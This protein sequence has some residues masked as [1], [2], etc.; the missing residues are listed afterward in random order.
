MK[1][2]VIAMCL[3]LVVAGCAGM[4]AQ[5]KVDTGFGVAKQVYALAGA[6]Y[7]MNKSSMTPENQAL[8]EKYLSG[9]ALAI[10]TGENLAGYAQRWYQF[11]QGA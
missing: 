10:D 1:L 9:F 11:Q 7:S 4:T 3:F 2:K 6:Y 8:F 5:Q